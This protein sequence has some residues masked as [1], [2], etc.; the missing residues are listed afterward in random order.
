MYTH[1]PT[2]VNG[3]TSYIKPS[4]QEQMMDQTDG[5]Q[6]QTQ[7]RHG[8]TECQSLMAG[9]FVS[10]YLSHEAA[11]VVTHFIGLCEPSV[12]TAVILHA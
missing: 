12:L 2:R 7:G 4:R 9:Q 8:D 11:L 3:T 1:I 5:L 6:T 10:N